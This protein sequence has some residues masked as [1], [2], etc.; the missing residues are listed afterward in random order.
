VWVQKIC[1]IAYPSLDHPLSPAE[2]S[3]ILV[4]DAWVDSLGHEIAND[5]IG[6]SGPEITAVP[7]YTLP[8][9]RIRICQLPLARKRGGKNHRAPVERVIRGDLELFFGCDRLV[10]GQ[11][12]KGPV[13]RNDP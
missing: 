10:V 9:G 4:K 5:Q 11:R 13:I 2:I 8:K 3:G 12:G 1:P 7:L 6:V